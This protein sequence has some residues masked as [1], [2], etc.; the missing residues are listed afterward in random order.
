MWST[1]VVLA[2]FFIRTTYTVEILLVVTMVFVQL[3]KSEKIE[4]ETQRKIQRKSQRKIEKYEE[5]NQELKERYGMGKVMVLNVVSI[6]LYRSFKFLYGSHF[7]KPFQRANI[8]RDGESGR[9]KANIIFL[10]TSID[11]FCWHMICNGPF[12]IW[13]CS[14]NQTK[15]MRT[16]KQTRKRNME[17]SI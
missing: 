13:I 16:N 11:V 6:I 2:W 10:P 3:I 1:H 14:T 17:T 8:W 5:W 4:M 7:R 9:I 12:F 15:T